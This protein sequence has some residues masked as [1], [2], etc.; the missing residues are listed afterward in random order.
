MWT[1]I[2]IPLALVWLTATPRPATAVVRGALSPGFTPEVQFDFEAD[3]PPEFAEYQQTYTTGEPPVVTYAR[4]AECSVD[5]YYGAL[6]VYASVE[7]NGITPLEPDYYGISSA[8]DVY[9][10]DRFN[11]ESSVLEEGDEVELAFEMD[12]V[13]NGRVDARMFVDRLEGAQKFSVLSL[14]Y[15]AT[16]GGGVSDFSEGSIVAKV[17]ERY[18][19]EYSL[20]TSIMLTPFG[21]SEENPTKFLVSDYQNA[22]F[23]V[24]PVSQPGVTLAATS[25]HDYTRVPESSAASAGLVVLGALAMRAACVRGGR[26]HAR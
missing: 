8:A 25:G 11:V 22:R 10:V 17:G 16:G 21:L 5:G 15:S 1:R 14:S 26:L 9:V 2:W 23:Y 19:I 7:L 13:G 24:E 6:S 3:T 20:G 18:Q 12:V 4:S